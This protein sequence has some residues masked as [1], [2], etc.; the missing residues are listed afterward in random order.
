MGKE[1]QDIVQLTD[2]AHH[3]LQPLVA[4]PRVARDQALRAR[5]RRKADV[6]GPNWPDQQITDAFAVGGSTLHWWRPRC[7]EDGLDTALARPP[8]ARPK[9]RTR[10][11]PQAARLVA[12]ACR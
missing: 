5:M 11:G 3:T 9:P 1:A 2:E 12:L 4:G 10:D 6:E 8:P 7:G